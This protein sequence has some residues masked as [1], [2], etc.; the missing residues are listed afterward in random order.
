MIW[1]QKWCGKRITY[2]LYTPGTQMTL[3]LTGVWAFF[4]RVKNH[5]K[6]RTN[7]FQVYIYIYIFFFFNMV[8]SLQDQR[9]WH[10]NPARVDAFP[11]DAKES[12]AR[13]LSLQKNM[14]S[15]PTGSAF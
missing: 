2:H 7:R 10:E 13:Q 15:I 6:Q 14:L 5:P 11:I 3:V 9:G 1:L 4:W 8:V 12:K